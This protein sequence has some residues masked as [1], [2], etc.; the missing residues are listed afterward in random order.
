MIVE[1]GQVAKQANGAALVRYGDT[2]FWLT[3]RRPGGRLIFPLTVDYE[4]KAVRSRK[5][6]R[7]H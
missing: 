1:V 5:I 4:R 3:A 2:V 7:L 6:Q